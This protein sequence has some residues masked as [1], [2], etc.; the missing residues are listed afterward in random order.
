MVL[1]MVVLVV[2][3]ALAVLVLRPEVSLGDEKTGMD[4][5]SGAD[6]FAGRDEDDS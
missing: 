6:I 3:D 4:G 1:M 2:E 5:E